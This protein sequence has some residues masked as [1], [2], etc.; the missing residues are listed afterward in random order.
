MK[1]IQVLEYFWCASLDCIDFRWNSI[2][3]LSILSTNDVRTLVNSRY[4]ASWISGWPDNQRADSQ[5]WERYR[6]RVV[7]DCIG[8]TSTAV[9][10]DQGPRVNL[11]D[12]AF[13]QSTGIL[14]IR[15]RFYHFISKFSDLYVKIFNIL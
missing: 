13:P 2:E 1:I 12:S 14:K 15:I 4:S 8:G 7:M 9:V 10:L 5:P 11:S 3:F 6:L